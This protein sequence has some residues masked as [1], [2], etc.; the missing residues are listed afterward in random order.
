MHFRKS[1]VCL[2]MTLLAGCVYEDGFEY[3]TTTALAQENGSGVKGAVVMGYG[4][5]T[6]PATRLRIKLN[7]LS[8]NVTY[9]VRLYDASYCGYT[10]LDNPTRIDGKSSDPNR[11]MAAWGFDGPQTFVADGLWGSV[12]KEFTLTPPRAPSPY[13][14]GP[15]KYPT[16]VIYSSETAQSVACGALSSPPKNMRPHT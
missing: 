15:S 4:I 13:L 5:H 10:E 12:E 9:E 2:G 1:L 3:Q 16:V 7:G 8:R 6:A 11:P 14:A